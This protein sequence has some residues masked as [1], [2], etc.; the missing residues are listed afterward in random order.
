MVLAD[1]DPEGQLSPAWITGRVSGVDSGTDLA[2][3]VNGS[4]VATTK[5][6]KARGGETRLAVF[7]PESS[8]VAGENEVEI[9]VVGADGA[10]A[11]I[12]SVTP[13]LALDGDT[14]RRVDG[15]TLQL[16]PA[17]I[18]GT[19]GTSSLTD[20]YTFE[21]WAVDEKRRRPVDAV[22]VF[23]DGQ[24]V[25]IARGESLRSPEPEKH[26]G[27]ADSGFAFNLPASVLPRRGRA[28]WSGCSR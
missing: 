26:R 19:V 17:E 6:Y 11:R 28:T 3:A 25:Y 7:V 20:R 16:A 24:L 10:L 27:V 1:Y 13:S 14:V 5:T 8:L 9:L 18:V 21:G 15:K 12:A 4:V 23:A 22:A 2:V